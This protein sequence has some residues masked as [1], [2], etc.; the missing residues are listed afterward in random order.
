[1]RH[2]VSHRVSRRRNR[3]RIQDGGIGL[4]ARNAP[5]AQTDPAVGLKPQAD[6]TSTSN[7][8]RIDAASEARRAISIHMFGNLVKPENAACAASFLAALCRACTPKAFHAKAQ[9]RG[10]AAHPGSAYAH[11]VVYAEG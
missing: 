1:M 7:L 8:P 3:S 6:W 4:P 9:G 10:A 5:G 2:D 11:T